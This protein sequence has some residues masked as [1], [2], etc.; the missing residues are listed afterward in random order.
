MSAAGGPRGSGA[1][2]TWLRLRIDPLRLALSA[3]PCRAAGFLLTYLLVSG[4]LLGIALTAGVLAA[5][6][7]CTVVA[8]PLVNGAAWAIRGCASVERLRLRQ[9]LTEPVLAGY[10]R[11]VQAGLRRRARAMWSSRSIWRELAYLIGL[12]PLLLS[13]DAVVLAIW[14]GLLAGITFPAWYSRVRGACIGSCA[15]HN[16]PGLRI[17][18]FPPGQHAHG[19]VVDSL[20]AA[21]VVAGVVLVVLML[22]NYVLV[23]TARLHARVARAVLRHPAD[24]LAPARQVLASPGPLRPL[25]AADR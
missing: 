3:G 17:G 10:A 12:W 15:G 16:A 2:A 25:T 19:I 5:I 24:P 6:L 11:P 1:D 13:L 21:L 22:F 14:T 23:A 8:A 4:L 9:V 7:A 18:D 20:P